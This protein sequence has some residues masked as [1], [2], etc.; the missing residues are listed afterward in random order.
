MFLE[1]GNYGLADANIDWSAIAHA[2]TKGI[3]LAIA[4]VAFFMVSIFLLIGAVV[5]SLLKGLRMNSLRLALFSFLNLLFGLL[6]LVF[7]V[8]FFALAFA[9]FHLKFSVLSLLLVTVAIAILVAFLFA[10]A[11]RF[12]LFRFLIK[13]ESLKIVADYLNRIALLVQHYFK[14]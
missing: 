5:V 9:L 13:F 1:I 8:V 10:S 4:V 11:V 12:I 14:K 2:L 3:G 6:S 7:G